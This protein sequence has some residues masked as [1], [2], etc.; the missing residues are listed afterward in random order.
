MSSN[1]Y[2]FFGI[3]NTSAYFRP[4]PYWFVAPVD[5]TSSNLPIVIINTDGGATIRDDPRVKA[6]MKIIYRGENLRNN[7]SDLDKSCLSQL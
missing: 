5:F 2:L 7:L 1:A 3:K 4:V 6:D